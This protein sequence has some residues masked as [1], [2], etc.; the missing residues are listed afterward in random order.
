LGVAF[1]VLNDLEDWRGQPNKL[2]PGTD[3]LA[4]RPTILWA[5]ALESLPAHD[6]QRLEALVAGPADD[7]DAV[8]KE[9]RQL[10]DR[11]GVFERAS[12]LIAKHRQRAHDVA[13]SLPH[14]PLAHLF[15]YLADTILE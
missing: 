2:T 9:V 11:A 3:V 4:G 6:C 14:A 7:P 10:Y 15:H 8:L 5:F 1:Q 12:R 13:E